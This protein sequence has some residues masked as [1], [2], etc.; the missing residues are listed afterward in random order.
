MKSLKFK[1]IKA[2]IFDFDGV[3]FDTEPLWFISAIASLKKLKLEYNK[4]MT[5]RD[6]I[7]IDSNIVFEKLLNKKSYLL[8]KKKID[9]VYK[10]ELKLNF[11]KKIKPF[12]YLKFFL[13]KTNLP[14]AIVSNSSKNHIVNLLTKSNLNK[15]FD[16]DKIISCNRDIR[17]KPEP[18]GYNLGIKRLGLKPSNILVIEDSEVGITSAKKANIFNILRFTNNDLNL[19]NKIIHNDVCSFRSF[20][21]LFVYFR[22]L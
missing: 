4:K 12:P 3:I 14:T 16:N 15:Y 6:T 13:K 7:G 8:Q 1:N 5:Y 21:D 18:D 19:A 22:G 10:K 20:N 17:S 11:S 2:I 9:V